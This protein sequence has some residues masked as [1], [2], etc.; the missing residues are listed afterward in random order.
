MRKYRL[1]GIIFV[2]NVIYM[3]L[4]LIASHLLSPHFGSSNL[5]WTSVIGI[6]LLSSSLGNFL[7]G[8]VAD[9][10][11]S[12]SNVKVILGLTGFMVLLI[13][14]MQGM[15]LQGILQITS[16]IKIGAIIATLLLFFIPS[17]FIGM[18]SPIM[19]K[20][21][22]ENLERAGKTSGR[23]YATATL[24]SIVGTFLGGFYLI[25]NFG[26]KQIL[27]VLAIVL[28]LLI[29]LVEEIQ[30]KKMGKQTICWIGIFSIM[31]GIFLF[32]SIRYEKEQGELVAKGELGAY[33][34]Y[35][36]QYGNVG[37]YNLE[38]NG[39][40]YRVLNVGK[41]FQSGSFIEESKCNELVFAYTKYYDWMFQVNAQI[42]DT[43]M[44]GGAGYSYPKYYISHY[45]DKNMDVVEIDEGVTQIAKEY[46]Y[47]DKLIEDYQLEENER[48]HLIAQDGRVYLNQNEKKYDA[49]L[50]D[51]F[52]G[53]IPAKTL[54]TLE[55]V[56]KIYH[57]L[58][59]DGVYLSNIIASIE[60][61]DAEFLKAEVQTLKQV[62][63]HVYVVP[64]NYKDALD[65][66]QNVMVIATDKEATVE[67]TV[68]LDTTGSMILTDDICPVEQLSRI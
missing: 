5:V 7:G 37:I 49:I 36:T 18:L 67:E 11:N 48:L 43:L 26:S 32:S 27:Y 60:G 2:V 47:L 15:I 6:I 12:K 65:R 54:T 21:K 63:K 8:M 50:N 35:D 13:P 29:L 41:G 44:I 1:E 40:R 16:N 68:P 42:Q 17:M 56:Q 45:P 46:F 34:S 38:S 10:N 61:E 39:Q 62:F 23:I 22:L 25:P 3:I 24:G 51:A 19:I 33:V 66:K 14:L 4:E 9:K 59:Q 20:L 31:S 53:E 52:S 58:N 57:S 28:F 64:C 30:W 55:A